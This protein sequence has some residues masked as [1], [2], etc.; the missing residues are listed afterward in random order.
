MR[1]E[2]RT[3]RAKKGFSA[4]GIRDMTQGSP[5]RLI[6]AFAIPLLIGNI[7]QQIYTMADTMVLGRNLGGGAIAAVGS[8]SSLYSLLLDFAMGMNSGYGIVVTR[9]FG[10]RDESGMRQAVAG[11]IL[12]NLAVTAALTVLSLLF[13]RPLM[14]AMNTPEAVFT[15]AYLYI[16]ILCGGMLATICS[17][18]C[19][20]ILRAAGDSRSPL[21]F[22]ILSCIVN[23]ALDVLLVAGLRWGVAG[24]AAAT[25]IAQAVSAVLCGGYLVKRYRF[26]LPVKEDF[27]Q[28][29]PVL[30]DLISTGF[31]MALMMCVVDLGS[32]V[33][34]RANNKLGENYIAAHTASRRIMSVMM[35]PLSSIA[36]ASSAF[37]GQNW[38]AQKR[39]RI[40]LAL[41]KVLGMAL[42]GGLFSCAAAWLFGQ[43]MAELS[44][45]V[46]D[47]TIVKNAALSL[48]WHL[49][50]FPV[51]GLL[52]CLRSSM[53]AM[54]E[55]R[56]P[57][58][59][60]G[61]ELAMK[62]FAAWQLAPR[63]GFLGICV[64]EPF[65]WAL[66]TIFLGSAYLF[67]IRKRLVP[68]AAAAL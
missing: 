22:L 9:R 24:A 63:I 47:E 21:Y 35:Q 53:Q 56:V 10:A 39:E 31:A 3:E 19:S 11:M 66:M 52:V 27:R 64:A 38:G 12:L 23:V 20:A 44:I 2:Q 58:L 7:F 54:G 26:L 42:C 46:S 61:I 32:A 60:S 25:V 59:S 68:E 48:R 55:K 34:Q 49:S 37:V 8:T 16:A 67:Q 36:A 62:I 4:G 51:L 57:V 41:Q 29:R 15:Q 13:L 1:G 65:A 17:N 50:F 14:R 40:R 5:V 18:M 30:P 28:I 6:L 45:G 33:F 43:E